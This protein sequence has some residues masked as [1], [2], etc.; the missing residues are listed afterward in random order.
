MANNLRTNDAIQDKMNKMQKANNEDGSSPN[1][2]ADRMLNA[3][4]III[5][6]LIQ[7]TIWYLPYMQILWI[8]FCKGLNG[9]ILLRLVWSPWF[10][11]QVHTLRTYVHTYIHTY[12]LVC[13]NTIIILYRYKIEQKVRNLLFEENERSVSSKRM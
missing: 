10:N 4:Y 2:V 1:T 5:L 9:G 6:I 3:M 7:Y 12:I 8:L 13:T 11:Q